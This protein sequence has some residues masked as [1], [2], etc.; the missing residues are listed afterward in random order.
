LRAISSSTG[1]HDFCSAWINARSFRHDQE[2]RD[3]RATLDQLVA[4]Q[5]HLERKQRDAEFVL[6]DCRAWLDGL[7]DNAALE[8]A[9]SCKPGDDLDLGD[10][11]QRIDDAMDEIRQLRAVPT[12]G[13]DIRERIEAYMN[14]LARPRIS[15]IASGQ[16]LRVDW[17]GNMIAVMALLLPEQMMKALL[18]EI[19]HHSNTP[20]SLPE[21]MKRIAELEA[22][23][24]TLQRRALALGADLCVMPAQVIL[25][26]RA[27][28]PTK[29]AA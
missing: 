6:G 14:G 4:D 8:F 29:R 7:P 15:G 25:G 24:D 5:P 19:E 17:P 28:R 18:Q 11:R 26:V 13:A 20:M 16:Q 27:T 10:A 22:Q 2:F 3:L 21:R 1:F 12:P 23:V 9:P